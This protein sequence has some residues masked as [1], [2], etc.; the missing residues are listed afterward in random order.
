MDMRGW[1][2]VWNGHGL[3]VRSRVFVVGSSLV[4]AWFII[5]ITKLTKK[6][7]DQ[8]NKS[9]SLDLKPKIII[10]IISFQF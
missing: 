5:S 2:V 7:Q 8:A 9:P 1:S 6:I 10:T 3:G 4:L